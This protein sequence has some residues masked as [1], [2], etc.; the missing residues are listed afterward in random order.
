MESNIINILLVEDSP[1]DARLVSEMMKEQGA[2]CFKMTHVDSLGEALKALS[3]EK[4]DAVLLDMNL[5]DS[6]GLI[7]LEKIFSQNQEVAVIL[8]TGV[9]DEA[10]G[11]QAIKKHASDYLIKGKITSDVLIRS[12]HYAVERKRFEIELENGRNELEIKVEERTRELVEQSSILEAF[13]KHTLTPLIFLDKDFNFI[14]V[15][16]AYAKVCQRSSAEFIGRNYFKLYPSPELKESFEHALKTKTRYEIKSRPFIFPEHPEWGVSYWDMALL[17]I[18][19]DQAKVEFLVLSLNDITKHRKREKIIQATNAILKLFAQASSR[20]EYLDGVVNLIHNVSGCQYVG[21]RMLDKD[22]RIPYESYIGYSREFWEAENWLS[23]N[24]DQ[25]ACIR[26]ITGKPEIQ[27][28]AAMTEFGSFRCE[29]MAEFMCGVSKDGKNK[30][31]SSCLESGFTSLGVIPIRYIDKTYGAIHLA[32]KKSNKT[33][34]DTIEIIEALTPLIGEGA[35]KFDMADKVLKAQRELMQTKRLS[36]IGT[37]SATVA[38]ELRNPLAAIHMASYNIKRKAQNPLLDKHLL[39]IEK[40]VNE[41]DQIINNL[42]FYSRLR[43][44]Q[45]ENINICEI[46][47]ECIKTIK[48]R[49]QKKGI[50][51]ESC[52]KPLKKISI[53]ADPLQMK[54]VFNNILGNACDAMLNGHGK[55]EIG[56]VLDGSFIKLSVK[57]N[58]AGIASEDLLRIFDPFFTTKAKG[59]GLGLTVCKQIIDFHNGA[60]DVASEKDKGTTFTIKLPVKR[61]YET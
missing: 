59:T 11:M 25:C 27:D 17:P 5:P 2:Y 45:Y 57:D 56:G 40:K 32:D 21:I 14:R 10:I 4:F 37:L 33:C 8:L 23:V 55:I 47:E 60:I 58:G 39:T 1:G 18:L 24:N 12:I 6:S 13:Y 50:S 29:N 38:H 26:V 34:L 48:G 19:D 35:Y 41:S 28:K 30:F 51:I 43:S 22:G 42:L 44:P 53:E 9:E 3:D 16:D 20:K 7:G 36:D 61:A 31:R 49:Y 15:N 46:I 54:E 52:L